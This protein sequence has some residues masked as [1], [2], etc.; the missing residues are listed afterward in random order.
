[1]TIALFMLLK[2]FSLPSFADWSK[3]ELQYVN[4]HEHNLHS[5]FMVIYTQIQD[6]EWQ[7][8]E[9]ISEM[10]IGTFSS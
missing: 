10:D 6:V 3:S 2:M 1:M 7:G 8:D 5:H 9:E 4:N